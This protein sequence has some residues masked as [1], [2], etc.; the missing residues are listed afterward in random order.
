MFLVKD[1]FE[2]VIRDFQV[3]LFVE[4]VDVVIV[5]IFVFCF[6]ECKFVIICCIFFFERFIKRFGLVIV[7]GWKVLIFNEEN[8]LVGEFVVFCEVDLFIFYC[9]FYL[10]FFVF[11][12]IFQ[13]MYGEKGWCIV[14][15]Q[16]VFCSGLEKVKVIFQG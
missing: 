5:V 9:N 6:Y 16:F 2:V 8:F 7:D 4:N 12:G 10:K 1:F 14:I 13:I 15:Q 3:I 11:W